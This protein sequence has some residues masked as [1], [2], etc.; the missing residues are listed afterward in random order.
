MTS[1]FIGNAQ[2]NRSKIKIVLFLKPN[3]SV[4]HGTIQTGHYFQ[5]PRSFSKKTEWGPIPV[6]YFRKTD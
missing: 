1:R 3:I 5:I 2:K 6:S 4:K